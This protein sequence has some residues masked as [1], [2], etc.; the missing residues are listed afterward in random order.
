MLCC[1]GRREEE[2]EERER[3][4][5]GEWYQQKEKATFEGQQG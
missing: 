2:R 4:E 3:V 1:D 5:D